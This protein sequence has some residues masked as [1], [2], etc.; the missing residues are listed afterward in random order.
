M[1]LRGAGPAST[2]EP[3]LPRYEDA[4]LPNLATSVLACLGVPGE[5]NPLRLP[6]AERVCLLLIDGLG[7]EL[8]RAHPAAAPL[9]AELSQTGR[10]LT[11]G[12]PATTAT[13]LGSIGTG[14]APGMHGLLGYQVVVPGSGSLLNALRWDPGVDPL[15]W[16]PGSTIFERAAAAGVAVSYVAPRALRGSG[17]SAAALRGPVYRPADTLGAL[18]TATAAALSGPGPALA[19]TYYGDLDATGHAL[20]CESD[21]WRYQLAHVDKLAEQIA[22][23]LPDGSRMYVTADHGMVDVPPGSRID[24]DTVP[25]L[26]DGIALLGGEPRARH[27][28]CQPGAEADVEAAWTAILGGDAWVR[29]R[30]QAIEA[31]WFGPVSPELAP[32]IGDLVVAPAGTAAIVATKAEPLESSLIGMHGSATAAEQLVPLLTVSNE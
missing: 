21:A 26:R 25:G 16:Q 4:S 24:V 2:S 1:A 6:P 20:G 13:S 3:L 23:A 7:W 22:A 28:Y 15:A 10:A 14:R 8:L 11:A 31:G 12:F 17:L 9:L 30:E 27:V 29:S 18:V 19:L 5:P 32:R